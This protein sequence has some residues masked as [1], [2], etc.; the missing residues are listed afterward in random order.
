[1][2]MVPKKK[3]NALKQ[4]QK[5]RKKQVEVHPLLQE[6]ASVWDEMK[7]TTKKKKK[8]FL[9]I[10]LENPHFP[11]QIKWNVFFS[12]KCVFEKNKKNNN[13]TMKVKFVSVYLL[14]SDVSDLALLVRIFLMPA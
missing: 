10:V 5:W 8:R 3:N 11:R 1:M 9:V 4:K 6:H 12:F 14:N 2:D 13:Y 7:W